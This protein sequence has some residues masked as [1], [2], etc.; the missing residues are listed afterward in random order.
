[1]TLHL[2]IN[3]DNSAF[4]ERKRAETAR[5]LTKLAKD[6]LAGHDPE[7]LRDFNGNTCGAIWFTDGIQTL[8][9]ID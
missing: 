5:I 1:M 4:E 6:I 9:A 7:K 8:H 3:M 2:K